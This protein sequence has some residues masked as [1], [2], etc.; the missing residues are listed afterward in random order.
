MPEHVND[1]G[2]PDCGSGAVPGTAFAEGQQLGAAEQG[3]PEQRAPFGLRVRTQDRGGG[4]AGV[5]VSGAKS[6]PLDPDAA[7]VRE[8]AN[9]AVDLS[10]VLLSGKATYRCLPRAS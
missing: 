8:I 4:G 3:R 7:H 1:A 6:V 2:Q 10:R 9:Q 5:D